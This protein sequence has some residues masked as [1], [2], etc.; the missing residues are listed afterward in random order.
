[1]FT[2]QTRKIRII[3]GV[4]SKSSCRNPLKK[5]DVLPVSCQY[6]LFLMMF[7][8]DNQ[9]KMRPTYL[10]MDWIPGTRISCSCLFLVFV[11]TERCFLL[12]YEDL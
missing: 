11:F 3:S 2:L 5:L 8:G 12:C 10:Y 1:V 7:V 4:G 9:K 6:M